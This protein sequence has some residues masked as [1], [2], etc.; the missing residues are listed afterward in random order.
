MSRYLVEFLGTAIFLSSIL[1]LVKNNI[2]YT[3]YLIGLTLTIVILGGGAIS[4]GH[5]NPAV[6]FMFY[7][8][9]KLSISELMGYIFCQLLG[10][11]VS[12]FLITNI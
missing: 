8:N 9:N 7:L 5:Y 4:G 11:F 6:S 3:P 1:F 10:S 2:S 12:Y